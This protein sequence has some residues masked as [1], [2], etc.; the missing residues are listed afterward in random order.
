MEMLLW[1]YPNMH[2]FLIQIYI[3]MM[4]LLVSGGQIVYE[5]DK[6]VCV[7]DS[8]KAVKYNNKLI[9]RL[10]N[11]ITIVIHLPLERY[12]LETLWKHLIPKPTS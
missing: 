5:N 12:Y 11:I 3:Y 10:F 4:E 9:N 6:W 1:Q 8:K 2:H 7:C